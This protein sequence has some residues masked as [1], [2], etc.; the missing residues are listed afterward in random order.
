[1]QPEQ[2]SPQNDFLNSARKERRP[3]DVYLI[4]GVRLSGSI[5]SFDQFVVVLSAP[6]GN[7]QAVYKSAV[8]T[9]QFHAPGRQSGPRVRTAR[10]AA[11][12]KEAEAPRVVTRMRRASR[13]GGEGE[14]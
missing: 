11:P 3:V 1:M 10:D 13:S 14:K 7:T 2:S 8:S 6:N 9:I 5:V 12:Y 4:N